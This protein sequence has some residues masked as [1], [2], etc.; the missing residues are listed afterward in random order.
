MQANYC[1]NCGSPTQEGIRYCGSCGFNLQS[2]DQ[3]L[4]YII[5]KDRVVLMTTLSAGLYLFYWFYITWKQYKE[6]SGLEVHPVWHA[7][8]LLVPIYGLF[9]TH[10]HMRTYRELMVRSGM[11]S[12]INPGLAVGAVLVSIL[13]DNVSLLTGTQISSQSL[14]LT[15]LVL[16]IISVGIIS[17]LLITIQNELNRYWH[18]VSS[19][20]TVSNIR[21]GEVVFAV[22]GILVWLEAI[23]L[24][25]S[26]S[27]RS[28]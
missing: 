15:Y 18:T 6:H 5:H 22:I 4:D 14:A 8:T 1:S 7:L 12:T 13:L 27:Y 26:E 17:W 21:V 24:V 28:F 3:P 10:A 16:S 23:V 11:T 9:R 19:L 2:E 20:S 25:V